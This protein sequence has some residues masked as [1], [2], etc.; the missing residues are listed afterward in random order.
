MKLTDLADGLHPKIS[1]AVYHEHLPALVSSTAIGHVLRTPAHYKAWLDETEDDDTSK[2]RRFG[3]AFHCC[4][5][6]PEVFT[7]KYAVE[8]D[9]GSCRKNDADGTTTEQGKV[10]KDRRDRW[11]AEHA[12]AELVTANDWT[13]ITGMARALREH[14]IAGKMLTGGESELTALWTDE[15][16]GLRSKARADYHRAD[17]RTIF[18]LKT[19]TDAS[20]DEFQ[21]SVGKHGYHRQRVHYGDGFAALGAPIDNF[22]FIV[23]EK[24][25]PYAVALYVLD[26]AAVARARIDVA[27]AKTQL[28]ECIRMNEFPAYSP[29][30]QTMSLP[31]WA[32]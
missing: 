24:T 22:V 23:V 27:T 6:E 14:P 26:A 15:E 7:K 12:F 8:P 9:F 4:T 31:K 2:A 13:A 30:I 11:R 5:L 28:A 32:A 19:A 10:N 17:L 3:R 29:S 21:R 16:T 1:D 20:F 25:P 18:D